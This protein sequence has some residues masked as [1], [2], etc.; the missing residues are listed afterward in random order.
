MKK[1]KITVGDKNYEITAERDTADPSL[2]SLTVD[3]KVHNVQIEEEKAP[4]ST[5]GPRRPAAPSRSAPGGSGS[6]VAQIPG[7]VLAVDVSAGDSVN[8]GDTLMVLEAMKMENVITAEVSGA[9]QAVHV[10]KGD[11]VVAGQLMMEIA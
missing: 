11:K 8:A 7:T 4:K 9:V 2:L 5:P 10:A 6:I 3:G 1:F